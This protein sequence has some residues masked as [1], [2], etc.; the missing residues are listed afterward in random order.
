MTRSNEDELLKEKLMENRTLKQLSDEQ[1]K[2]K[3]AKGET[4]QDEGR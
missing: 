4:Q 1:K 2:Q 3:R